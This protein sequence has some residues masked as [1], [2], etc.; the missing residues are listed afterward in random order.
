MSNNEFL[1]A[2][3][4]LAS[5]PESGH[6]LI[7]ADQQGDGLKISDKN[8]SAS[9]FVRLGMKETKISNSSFT[10]SN[11]ED[12][13][14]RK[15]EFK[16]VRFTGSSFRFCN[17]DKAT[18][19]NCDFSYCSFYHC[20]LT[21]HEIKASLPS[22]P[23]LRK[24]I[25]K[26]LRANSEMMGDKESA[27]IFLDTEIQADEEESWAIFQSDTEY[28]KK[29]YNVFDQVKSFLKFIGSK[30]SGVIWGYGHRVGRLFVSYFLFTCLWS[31]ST[32]IFKIDFHVPNEVVPRSINFWESIYLGFGQTVGLSGLSFEP[33]TSTGEL[34]MLL[35]RFMGTLFLAL[36]VAAF[37]RR[38]AR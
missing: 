31:F 21:T 16:N 5:L 23:N 30:L 6:L 9:S 1:R 12:S 24:D 20:K 14:F 19:E 32:F 8:I 27:D 36:F 35:A 22:Q 15:A 4:K 28:Y 33:V 3:V 26:N 38:I 25:A 37:Y 17:F 34:L 7:I 13:Y 10:Q 11:F 29:R 2:P 18:F